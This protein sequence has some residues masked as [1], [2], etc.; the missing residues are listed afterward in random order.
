M[1]NERIK[2]VDVSSKLPQHS[3]KKWEKRSV[4]KINR[5][6]IHHSAGHITSKPKDIA[7]DHISR[8]DW[9]GIAYH[10][11]ISYCT[12]LTS[13]NELIVYQVNKIEDWT[14]HTGPR[15]NKTGIG[16]LIQ[17]CFYTKGFERESYTLDR[18]SEEQMEALVGLWH[19][20]KWKYRICDT[21]LFGHYHAGKIECPGDF[22]KNWI[23]NIRGKTNDF[24][25]S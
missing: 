19:F 24:R 25:I 1:A 13:K 21:S 4:N 2:I 18:P 6:I 15:F 7:Q 17:G 10:Y 12:P 14:W 20:L 11:M 23:E 3:R 5:A 9:P 8:L 22:L 16:I